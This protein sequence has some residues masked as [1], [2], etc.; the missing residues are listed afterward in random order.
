MIQ[1]IQAEPIGF[2][3]T[4]FP[5]G[6]MAVLAIVLPRVLVKRNTRSQSEVA[7]TIWASG[8]ILFLVGA[9]VFAVIYHMRG[10]DVFEAFAEGPWATAAFF[11]GFSAYAAIVWAPILGLVWFGMAQGVEARKGEDMWRDE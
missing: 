5:L 1:L 9:G 8:G 6:L 3:N 4:G 7:V 10:Y 2:W 11:F